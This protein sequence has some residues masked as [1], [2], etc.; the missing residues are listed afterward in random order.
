M[1]ISR[2]RPTTQAQA[3]GYFIKESQGYNS[4]TEHP[5]FAPEFGGSLLPKLGLKPGPIHRRRVHG[6]RARRFPCAA[7]AG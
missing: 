6:I 7:E 2:P 1:S 3:L 5:D 4:F